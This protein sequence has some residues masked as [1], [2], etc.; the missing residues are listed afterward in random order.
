[1]KKI[2]FLMIIG[3]TL[4]ASLA[5]TSTLYVDVAGVCD[6]NLSCYLHPQD[7]VNAA[8]AG[9]TILVYPGTYGSRNFPCPWTP[10]CSCSDDN[11]PALI[12]YKDDLTIQAVDPDPALTVIESTHDCWSNPMAVAASTA[13]AISHVASPNGVTVFA[14]NATI[15]GFTITSTYG[16]DPNAPWQYPNTGGVFIGGL[17]GGDQDSFGLSGTTIKNCVVR[18]YSGMRLWKAPDTTLENNSIDNDIVPV[19]PTTPQQPG[20]DVWDGWCDAGWCEGPDVGSANLR[21][22][23]NEITAVRDRGL[24]LGGYYLGLMMDHSDLYGDG[25]VIAAPSHGVTFWGSGGTNKVLTCNN[26]VTVPAGFMKVGVWWGTYDG[27]YGIDG[28]GDGVE[29]CN[30]IAIDL[31]PNNTDNQV[32]TRAKMLVPI[33]VLGSEDFDP[34][35]EVDPDTVLVRGAGP[36]RTYFDVEDVNGDGYDDMIFYFR[37]REFGKPTAEECA[38]PDAKIKLTLTTYGGVSYW[39]EDDVNWLGPDCP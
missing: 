17:Y 10:N 37:A 34:I 6:G 22:I 8:T 26:T 7:A 9:D 29:D 24:S 16:G 21:L 2:L 30:V 38:D 1:V 4:T 35:L 14:N 15:D 25:N 18:G 20:I 12:V 27:P 3:V 31:R 5:Q 13:G 39:A 19:S 32:N 23:G 33:A 28:D 11:S 36:S